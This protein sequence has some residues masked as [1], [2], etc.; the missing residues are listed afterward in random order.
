MRTL[1]DILAGLRNGDKLPADERER[2]ACAVESQAKLLERLRVFLGVVTVEAT[3]RDASRIRKSAN[4]AIGE[5]IKLKKR[6]K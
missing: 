1:S 3:F 6:L 4:L 5:I 2:V